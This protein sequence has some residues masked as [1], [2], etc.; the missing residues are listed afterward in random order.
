M[1]RYSKAQKQS[2]VQWLQGYGLLK[3]LN[4]FLRSVEGAQSTCRHCHQK[5]Y[6]DVMVGGGVPDWSTEDG[7]FGCPK[8]PHTDSEGSG[9]HEPIKRRKAV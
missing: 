2:W 5:I 4:A 9:G 6:V 8:S 7:D 3:F 1:P